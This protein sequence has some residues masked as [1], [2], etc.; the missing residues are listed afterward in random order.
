M[1]DN[2]IHWIDLYQVD[3]AVSFINSYPLVSDLSI[4]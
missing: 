3:R 2:T 4:G 1:V